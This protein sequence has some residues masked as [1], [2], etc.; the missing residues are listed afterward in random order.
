VLVVLAGCSGG[1]SQ[2]ESAADIEAARSFERFPLYWLGERFENWDLVHVDVENHEWV[3]FIYGTCEATGSEGGCPPPLQLQ[4][5]PLC[6]HI[7]V[8]ADDP[9]WRQQRVRGAPVGL[10]D[11]APVLFTD[12]VQIKAYWG[13][14]AD[15]DAPMRALEALRSVNRVPPVLD[16]DDPIPPAPLRVLSRRLCG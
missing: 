6:N 13:Q 11:G 16:R 1:T 8:V 12:R 10:F 7:E 3:T 15:S 14:G 9:T 5:M 2:T 4:I